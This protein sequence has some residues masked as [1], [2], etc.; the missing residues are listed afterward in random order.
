MHDINAPFAFLR[1]TYDRLNAKKN[2][3]LNP[4]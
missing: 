1:K 3:T 4:T 2:K